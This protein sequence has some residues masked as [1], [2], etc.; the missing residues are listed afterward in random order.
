MVFIDKTLTERLL[1]QVRSLASEGFEL[2]NDI[3]LKKCFVKKY[4]FAQ[5]ASG[6]A[7]RKEKKNIFHILEIVPDNIT[8]LRRAGVANKQI[9]L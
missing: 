6:K 1:E 3:E 2:R 9:T 5:V 8:F 7:E 4:I